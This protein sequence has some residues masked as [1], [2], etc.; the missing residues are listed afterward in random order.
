MVSSAEFS[1]QYQSSSVLSKGHGFVCRGK[2]K[3]TEK[4][5]G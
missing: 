4:K 1:V 5:G 3:E 2:Q